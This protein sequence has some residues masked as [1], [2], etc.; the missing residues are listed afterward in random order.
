MRAGVDMTPATPWNFG[1]LYRVG[2]W[3]DI[4]ASYQRGNAV[5]LGVTLRTNF[6]DTKAYWLDEPM[7]EPRPAQ[8][9]NS[10]DEVDWDKLAGELNAI[11]G[12]DDVAIER[13]GET[14]TIVGKQKKY[15]DRDEARERAAR[16][17]ANHLPAKITTYHIIE[18]NLNLPQTETQIDA[19]T[20]KKI[21]QQ[22]PLDRQLTDSM[23]EKEVESNVSTETAAIEY[24]GFDRLQYSFRPTLAQSIGS[25]ENFYLYELGI[26]GTAD[27][28]ATK[29]LNL[30]GTVHLNVVDNY[31]KFNYIVPPDGTNVP[32]VRTLFRL[33]CLT[34]PYG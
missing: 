10:V 34:T 15:R 2:D 6:N 21:A 28:W 4:R 9:A 22:Q 18:T 26:D 20:F 8:V 33:M 24:D 25:A 5:A 12:Y 16:I 30:S 31:D 17:L 13:S 29:N 11:A 27:V 32:R 7:P 23:S 3:G 19:N 1:A 14:V